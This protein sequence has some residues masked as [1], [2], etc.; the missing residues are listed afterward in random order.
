MDPNAAC[1]AREHRNIF[2]RM[3]LD[4]RNILLY[5]NEVS[6][7]ALGIDYAGCFG[8]YGLRSDEFGTKAR[9]ELKNDAR[10]LYIADRVLCPTTPDWLLRPNWT[11]LMELG[12]HSSGGT[13]SL[14]PSPYLCGHKGQRFS[15][16][17]MCPLFKPVLDIALL[18]HQHP[19]TSSRGHFSETLNRRTSF[20]PKIRR[21]SYAYLQF[22]LDDNS[23]ELCTTC[24]RIVIKPEKC[25]FFQS[26]I[27][28]IVCFI[29]DKE[30]RRPDP[31]KHPSH[32]T[33]ASANECFG[34]AFVP[35]TDQPRS[36]IRPKHA[37]QSVQPMDYLLKHDVAWNCSNECPQA[38]NK[39]ITILQSRQT[40]DAITTR[41]RESSFLPMRLRPALEPSIFS[42]AFRTD[43]LLKAIGAQCHHARFTPARKE[44]FPN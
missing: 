28:Y 30:G 40:A 3:A 34:I 16:P 2:A 27:K 18:L 36:A 4:K 41:T 25:S 7:N 12:S 1:L 14:C 10:F 35:W 31:C 9:L 38:F 24:Q 21:S 37:I 5:P 32:C 17:R 15:T 29:V 33:N 22:E 44:L 39:V 26:Q 20:L 42:S 11:R 13:Y 43:T 6:I 8:S 19:F 23:K